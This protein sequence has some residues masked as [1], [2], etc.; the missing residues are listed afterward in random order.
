MLMGESLKI[1]CFM[2]V[3]YEEPG[4]IATWAEAH[5]HTMEYTRFYQ[6]DSLPG[7]GTLDLLVVMGGPMKVFDFH[8]HPWMQEEI[9][10]VAGY[11]VSG[12]P[13][14]GI[15]LGAQIIATALGAEVFP[16][17][18]REIG[19]HTLQFL[20]CLGGYRICKELPRSRKVFHWH[21]DTF[22]IPEG[23]DRIAGTKAF[24]NQGFIYHGRVIALQF[25]LEVTP[26][27]VSA[28]VDNCRDELVEGPYIQHEREILNEKQDF[29]ENQAL[30]FR[31]MDYLAGQA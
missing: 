24:P 18:Y 16:G 7:T 27:N 11:I 20:P 26:E 14:L 19:W 22:H 28:M 21:G 8:V 15:C 31:F 25:H 17:K 30:M 13:V 9:D 3:P 12:R 6:G 23:A 29:Q 5:G 1:G 2:H 10:W 4:V